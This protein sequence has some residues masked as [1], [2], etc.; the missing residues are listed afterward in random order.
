L[1]RLKTFLPFIPGLIWFSFFCLAPFLI[2]VIT[3]F[4]SR[5]PYGEIILQ[6]TLENYERLL[7]PVYL[8]ILWNSFKFAALTTVLTLLCGFPIALHT[9]NLKGKAQTWMIACIL[10]PFWINSI[11]K[12]YAI[13]SFFMTLLPWVPNKI[14]VLIGM[15]LNYLPFMI[16]PVFSALKTLDTSLIEAAYDL[17]ASPSKAITHVIIPL[18][19]VA[20]MTGCLFV[21]IPA[22]GEFAIPE[23]LG[24][25]QG[26]L[27]GNLITEQF[28]KTR[29]WPFGSA[30]SVCLLIFIPLSA[31]CFRKV[32][33]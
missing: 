30:L 11:V 5:G 14:L 15:V 26:M 13:K 27:I 32:S 1:K 12:T 23:I 21:F 24:N 2:F 28:L 20:I 31:F 17:S 19:R 9:I 18:T 29:D 6:F 16:M 10:L 22:L 8:K 3:S 25:S 4:T 7:N 33:P